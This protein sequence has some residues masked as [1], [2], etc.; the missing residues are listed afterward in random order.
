LLIHRHKPEEMRARVKN[1]LQHLAMNRGMQKKR[2]L[3][4]T[5]GQRAFRQLALP[6]WAGCRRADLLELLGYLDGKIAPLHRAAEELCQGDQVALLLK[7][8]PGAGP[9]TALAFA[10]TIGDASRFQ[11][12]KQVASYLGAD[13][14]R[15][16]LGRQA[17][18]GWDQ[19]ARQPLS[20]LVV[21]RGGAE[22][23]AL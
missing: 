8:Q 16:Q 19:Q 15:A 1:G 17:A 11:R 18:T 7:T 10:V 22:R 4:S 23:G 14:A 6:G 9:I 13:S 20:A 5:A 3:W 21:G 12:G 2:R